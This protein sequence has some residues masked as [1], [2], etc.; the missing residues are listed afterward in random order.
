MRWTCDLGQCKFRPSSIASCQ[1]YFIVMK[2]NAQ[3]WRERE[4]INNWSS[5][6]CRSKSEVSREPCMW[7]DMSKLEAWT[8]LVLFIHL[9]QSKNPKMLCKGQRSSVVHIGQYWIPEYL[10]L[11]ELHTCYRSHLNEY[12]NQFR[13][14]MWLLGIQSNQQ[15]FGQTSSNIRIDVTL[16]LL[17]HMT[18]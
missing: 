14:S 7:H 2:G 10:N 6:T 12:K 9:S 5:K 3:W 13:L 4:S 1:R 16:K 11:N 8:M 18:T 17:S 15:R